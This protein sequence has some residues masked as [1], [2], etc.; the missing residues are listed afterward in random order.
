MNL[1][2]KLWTNAIEGKNSYVPRKFIWDSHP[3]RNEE[4]KRETLNNMSPQQFAVEMECVFEGSSNTLI[5]G[6]KLQQLVF[7]DPIS[8]NNKYS[9]YEEIDKNSTYY[10]CVDIG[11]GVGKDY[12]V[13]SV[14]NISKIP[15]THAAVFRSN[16]T[17]A[18]L[19]SE[20]INNVSKAYNDAYCLIENNGIGQITVNSMLYDLE[21]ENLIQTDTKNNVPSVSAFGKSA[22]LRQTKKTKA[23]GCMMLKALI[24]SDTLITNDF[25]TIV[26]LNSFIKKG[27]SWEAEKRKTDD[28]VMT[29]VLF[30]WSIDQEF[31]EELLSESMR[32]KIKEKY[33]ELEE[34]N[35]LTFGFLDD[36][37][38]F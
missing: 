24:E 17:P 34:N 25:E 13:I 31:F 5:S 35:H 27:T 28:I 26:E 1:F 11:E 15:Y 20:I 32:S 22:G 33:L 30:A 29:L 38:D 12:S 4:W 6:Q 16:D 21:F 19:M 8:S 23:I 7:R 2:Y 14:F 36:G 10:V 18:L 37:I 3:R 9:V